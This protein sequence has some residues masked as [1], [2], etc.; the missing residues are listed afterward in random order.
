M[1]IRHIIELLKY[2]EKHVSQ[3]VRYI[4]CLSADSIS[5]VLDNNWSVLAE[6][7]NGTNIDLYFRKPE[8]EINDDKGQTGHSSDADE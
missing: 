2:V 3:P 1:K 5:I 6:W 8:K 7:S 4:E